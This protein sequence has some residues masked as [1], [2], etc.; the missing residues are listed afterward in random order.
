MFSGVAYSREGMSVA[1]KSFAA[2]WA[3]REP[4]QE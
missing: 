2:S 3:T 1:I 4:G